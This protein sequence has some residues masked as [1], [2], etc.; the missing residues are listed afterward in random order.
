MSN[1]LGDFHQKILSSVDG[2][3]NHDSGYDLECPSM[4]VLAEIK[5]KWNTMNSD[6]RRAVLSGLDVAVRQKASNWCGYLVIIIPKKCERYEKFIGNKIM[7]ID[8]ASFYH[9]VTGDP[10]AIHDLFDILSDKICP[11]SD[12]ASY[13]REIMEKSLPPRV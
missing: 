7:E 5:N 13:C 9:K 4:C 3:H 12:V 2:W 1:S 10:N 8:G 6:N 11:S